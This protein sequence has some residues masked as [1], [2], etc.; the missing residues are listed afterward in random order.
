MTEKEV[1]KLMALIKLAYPS[2]QNGQEGPALKLWAQAL[3]DV[4]PKQAMDALAKHIKE[5]KFAPTIAEIR[6]GTNHVVKLRPVPKFNLIE[7][8]RTRNE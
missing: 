4:D 6:S 8:V 7:S 2:F 3:S 1:G 5:C